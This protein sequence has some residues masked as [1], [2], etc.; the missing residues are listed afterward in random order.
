MNVYILHVSLLMY[1]EKISFHVSL[2]IY[3]EKEITK[4]SPMFSL[5]LDGDLHQSISLLKCVRRVVS[6]NARNLSRERTPIYVF[7]NERTS[8]IDKAI[9]K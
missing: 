8:R 3:N 4:I 9:M 6:G 5:F 2:S 1:N 7:S